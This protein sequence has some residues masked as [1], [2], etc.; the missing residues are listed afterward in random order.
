MKSP[1]LTK[2]LF[3]FLPK[4]QSGILKLGWEWKACDIN[5]DHTLILCEQCQRLYF[6]GAKN[7][8]SIPKAT[9]FVSWSLNL[10]SNNNKKKMEILTW[11]HSSCSWNSWFGDLLFSGA[12]TL[13][14]GLTHGRQALTRSAAPSVSD[15]YHFSDM[16]HNI[17]ECIVYKHTAFTMYDAICNINKC[18]KTCFGQ[19]NLYICTVH[20]LATFPSGASSLY[21]SVLILSYLMREDMGHTCSIVMT[22]K[23][24]VFIC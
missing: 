13:L 19:F 7:N 17:D 23:S 3:I 15:T 11:A 24:I 6:L 9:S 4:F 14:Q 2:V 18:N 1:S 21:F 10:K 5:L 16:V 20:F 22:W 12:M 8:P